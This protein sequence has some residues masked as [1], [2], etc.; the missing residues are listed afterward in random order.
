MQQT[1]FEE[2]K[3]E[4]AKPFSKSEKNPFYNPKKNE[5]PSN[6]FS[7]EIE[8]IKKNETFAYVKIERHVFTTLESKTTFFNLLEGF[9]IVPYPQ[10]F[11][12]YGGHYGFKQSGLE[13]CKEAMQYILDFKRSLLSVPFTENL[14][15]AHRFTNLKSENFFV[16]VTDETKKIIEEHSGIKWESFE[17]ELNSIRNRIIPQNYEHLVELEYSLNKQIDSKKKEIDKLKKEYEKRIDETSSLIVTNPNEIL[18]NHKKS[19]TELKELEKQLSELKNQI[20][21]ILCEAE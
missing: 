1:L 20:D 13:Q 21:C 7:E 9:T 17:S 5:T 12:C 2:K 3:Q 14:K 19:K 16:Q 18:E 11:S 15:D 8:D 10:E 4:E 6:V